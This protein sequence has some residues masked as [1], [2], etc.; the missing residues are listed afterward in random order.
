M[1]I[2]SELKNPLFDVPDRQRALRALQ[3]S[4]LLKENNHTKAWSVVK[5]MIDKVVGESALSESQ[6]SHSESSD[7]YT[8]PPTV[9]MNNPANIN[10]PVYVDQIPSYALHQAPEPFVHQL[11]QSA[12]SAPSAQPEQPAFNWDEL[13]LSSIVGDITQNPELPEFDFV[14]LQLNFCT[15]LFLTL[16]GILGG[17]RELWRWRFRHISYGWRR[18]RTV[19]KLKDDAVT[20]NGISSTRKLTLPRPDV[21]DE[22]LSPNTTGIQY[23]YEWSYCGNLKKGVRRA[24]TMPLPLDHPCICGNRR[25]EGLGFDR[26]IK[27]QYVTYPTPETFQGGTVERGGIRYP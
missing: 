3:M 5:G 2:L 10:F 15:S 12:P 8:S 13:N 24:I 14:S 19:F 27:G 21:D 4:R 9:T 17:P 1:H 11:V 26:S 18:L 23:G 6:R 20:K 16:I 25:L 22:P 7:S